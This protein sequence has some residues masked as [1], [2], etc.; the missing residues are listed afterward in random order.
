MTTRGSTSAANGALLSGREHD[1]DIGSLD[2]LRATVM[3]AGNGP[4]DALEFGLRLLRNP[5]RP[6][7]LA[8]LAVREDGYFVGVTV[9]AALYVSTRPSDTKAWR[10]LLNQAADRHR[11]TLYDF[12]AAIAR[13]QVSLVNQA[14][15][16]LPTLTPREISTALQPVRRSR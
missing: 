9:F 1:G 2:V 11:H 6:V 3:P 16:T 4:E 15:I 8:E 14:T 13:M 5:R 12:A 10:R 7:L